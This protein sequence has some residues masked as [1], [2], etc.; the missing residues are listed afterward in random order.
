MDDFALFHDDPAVLAEW[1]GRIGTYLARRRLSLHPR[2]TYVAATAEPTAF[3]GYVLLPNGRRRLPEDNVRRFRNRLRSMGDR[4][5][6]GSL[7]LEEAQPRIASWVAHARHANTR[8]LR[9]AL[10]RSGPF[11]PPPTAPCKTW[12]GATAHRLSDHP[13]PPGWPASLAGP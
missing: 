11:D 7:T 6:A 4:L 2:K 8:R 1:R 3:L 9:R 10:F 5:R 12:G 13:A